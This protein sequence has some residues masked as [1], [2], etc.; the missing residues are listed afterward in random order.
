M[1]F[2]QEG[3]LKPPILGPGVAT[4]EVLHQWESGCLAYFAAKGIAADKQVARVA[5]GLTDSMV[6]T[7]Y[8]QERD[9]YNTLPFTEFI[10]KLRQEFLDTDWT[11]AIHREI[12]K[13]AQ[14]DKSF[15]EVSNALIQ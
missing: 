4:P 13:M 6:Q 10:A 11:T 2:K 7:W 5:P 3:A 1:E 15:S 14:R 9:N 8:L 12:G